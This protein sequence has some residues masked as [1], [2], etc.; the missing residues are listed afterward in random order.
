M[1]YPEAIEWDDADGGHHRISGLLADVFA[2]KMDEDFPSIK[3]YDRDGKQIGFGV[4]TKLF[5]N[6]SYKRVAHTL[7]GPAWISTVWLGMDHGMEVLHRH[8]A[9]DKPYRPLI[10]ETMLFVDREGEW[11]A[12]NAEI[13]KALRDM[14]Q[15]CERWSTLAEAKAGHNEW[16]MKTRVLLAE[17]ERN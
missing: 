9:P 5:R 15:E 8:Y 6:L 4:Y 3:Y 7:V 2:R 1:T 12:T 11:A 16:V 14:D 10:F 17:S 13:P